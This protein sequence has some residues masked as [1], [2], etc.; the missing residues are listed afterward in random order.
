[1]AYDELM[2]QDAAAAADGGPITQVIFDFGNV[3]LY[4]D[5]EAVMIPRYS[6]RLV[7]GFLDNDVSSFYDA[8]DLMDAGASLE[9]GVAYVR[10]HR[11]EPWASMMRYYVDNF[12]DSLTGVVIGARVLIEDLHAAGI[13]VWGLSNWQRDLYRIAEEGCDLLGMLDGKVVS[14]QVKMRKPHRDIYEYALRTFGI[15]A[16]DTVFI[17]DKAMNIVGA[18]QAGIRGIRFHDPRNLRACLIAAG[19][20]IAPVQD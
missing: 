13:G 14:G 16:Q 8:N 6:Q 12:R 18:N 11:G 1:M 5:P 7:D 19:V 10:E 4:W 20:P 2:A 15:N 17:D 3:L 9:E